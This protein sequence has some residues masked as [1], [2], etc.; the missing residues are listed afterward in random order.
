MLKL[1]FRLQPRKK[2]VRAQIYLSNFK[3]WVFW[4]IYSLCI[5]RNGKCRRHWWWRNH[6]AYC[7][8]MLGFHNKISDFIEWSD[9]LC[10]LSCEIRLQCQP[11]TPWKE[12][13]YDWLRCCNCNAT[14]CHSGVSNWCICKHA[15]SNCNTEHDF[16][17]FACIFDTTISL[18]CDENL[19]KG[20]FRD[21]GGIEG[22]ILKKIENIRR[23]F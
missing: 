13:D 18:K 19:Q 10:R 20:N 15:P 4:S 1:I 8:N 14:S 6:S 23:A 16:D 5:D 2:S 7:C 9:N 22:S 21:G 11:K 17:R 3:N 12:S